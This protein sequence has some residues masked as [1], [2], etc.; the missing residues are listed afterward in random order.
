[1]TFVKDLADNSTMAVRGL[2]LQLFWQLNKLAPSM[3]VSISDLGFQVGDG[4]FPYLQP[5]AKQ[6]LEKV[7]AGNKSITINS[8]YRSVVAQAMLYSQQQ[9]GLIKNL[10]AYPGKSDHQR[11]ASIDVEE[12][13]DDSIM[14]ALTDV[15][16]QWTYGD[17]D[18]MH[19]DCDSEDVRDIR[20]MSIKAFQ[21]LWNVANPRQQ[22]DVDGSL[23]DETLNCIYNSPAEGFYNVGYPRILKLTSP[24]QIGTDVGKLQMA[25]RKAGFPIR[26]ANEIFSSVTDATVRAFQVVHKLIP[27]GIVGE[28]TRKI[29]GL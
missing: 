18:P 15:G 5:P 2:D 16:W 19:F 8:A 11:G 27:D 10:V 20:E 26:I 23:G 17:A 25:L 7:L 24:V 1:M 12:W 13:G 3:L 22:I 14:Q 28:E 9:R 21:T 29:L 4:L 6:E